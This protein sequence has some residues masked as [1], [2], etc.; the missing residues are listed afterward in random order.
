M[1]EYADPVID[2]LDQGKGIIN[3]RLFRESCTFTN[4]S[5]VKDLSIVDADLARVCLI[6]NSPA[7]YAK[8]RGELFIGRP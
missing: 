4:G 3:G 1:Q 6:D 8:N 7:S 5:Y 2:W